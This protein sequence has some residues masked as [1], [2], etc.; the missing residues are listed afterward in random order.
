MP[1][2]VGILLDAQKIYAPGIFLEL[3]LSVILAILLI[4]ASLPLILPSL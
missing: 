2:V 4:A 1:G 3:S